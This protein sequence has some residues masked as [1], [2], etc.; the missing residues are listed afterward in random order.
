MVFTVNDFINRVYASNPDLLPVVRQ[1]GD[2]VSAHLHFG[3]DMLWSPDTHE[4]SQLKETVS[5]FEEVRVN[6]WKKPI[7]VDAGYR[8][9]AHEKVLEAAGLKTAKF[10]SPHSLSS[11]HDYK[12]LPGFGGLIVKEN[13]QLRLA[14]RAG[15]AALNLPQ[16]RIGHTA[17]G[18]AFLHVDFMFLWFEPF[19]ALSHP[20]SWTD[21]PTDLRDIYRQVLVPGWEW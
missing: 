7:V 4:Y 12:A 14:F 13:N 18:E 5:L 3:T 9:A 2:E 17:Y 16:P 6:Q 8:T 10:V 20:S 19:T 11:A 21:L 15:A 1:Y